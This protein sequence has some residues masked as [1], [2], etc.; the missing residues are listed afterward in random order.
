MNYTYQS[1][2]VCLLELR[3]K[4]N[5]WTLNESF[6]SLYWWKNCDWLTSEILANLLRRFQKRIHLS[7]RADLCKNHRT[8]H[9]KKRAQN[10]WVVLELRSFLG[11]YLFHLTIQSIHRMTYILLWYHA[12]KTCI[13]D[14]SRNSRS[15]LSIC[16]KFVMPI[17]LPLLTRLDKSHRTCAVPPL[18]LKHITGHAYYSNLNS[19]WD[20]RCQIVTHRSCA[21]NGN[22]ST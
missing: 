5:E 20:S 19:L 2:C 8:L 21:Y 18:K 13:V 7:C 4:S 10:V 11:L 17:K 1:I 14:Q 9:I 15:R 3:E 6:S 22:D 16:Q 12:I